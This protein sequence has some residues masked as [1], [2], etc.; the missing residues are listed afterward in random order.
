MLLL[1]SLKAFLLNPVADVVDHGVFEGFEQVRYYLPHL[2]RGSF[3]PQIHE[4]I[5]H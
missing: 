5:L 3:L 2:Q 4:Q 1:V